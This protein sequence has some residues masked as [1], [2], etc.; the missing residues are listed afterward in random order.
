MIVIRVHFRSLNSR[1]PK[2]FNSFL[3][4]F[5]IPVSCWR[6]C[7]CSRRNSPVKI[8]PNSGGTEHYTDDDN[9]RF[10]DFPV[11]HLFAWTEGAAILDWFF[12]VMMSVLMAL[13]SILLMLIMIIGGNTA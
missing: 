2:W 12:F 11:D 10:E 8:R 9:V 7:C 1:V 13:V 6:G 5:C 4:K 3:H